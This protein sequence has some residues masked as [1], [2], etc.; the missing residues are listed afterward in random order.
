MRSAINL[1]IESHLAR[2]QPA[3][4][5]DPPKRSS[6]L[7]F[8]SGP[9]Q[10]CMLM[11]TKHTT[12]IDFADGSAFV[13]TQR[14]FGCTVQPQVGIGKLNGVTL[15]HSCCRLLEDGDVLEAK[16]GSLIYSK[17][18]PEH[19][20][21]QE[22]EDS[23]IVLPHKSAVYGLHLEDA[24]AGAAQAH[25]PSITSLTVNASQIISMDDFSASIAKLETAEPATAKSIACMC[26]EAQLCHA[27][28]HFLESQS[29]SYELFRTPSSLLRA[30]Q[31]GQRYSMLTMATDGLDRHEIRNLIALLEFSHSTPTMLMVEPARVEVTKHVMRNTHADFLIGPYSSD[32]MEDRI[33]E[34]YQK[35]V[36]HR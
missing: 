21:E 33:E 30:L 20:D 5:A 28:T 16:G 31:E 25:S 35:E 22:L 19:E 23:E 32:E 6:M 9:D 13:F 10:G 15:T 18:S 1:E 3:F 14:S 34:L 8:T 29:L 2:P 17:S 24:V 12:R 27:L 7:F 36:K 11:L 26:A 4:K